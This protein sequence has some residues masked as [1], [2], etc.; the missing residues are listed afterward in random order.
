VL[1]DSDAPGPQMHCMQGPALRYMTEGL[2]VHVPRQ[3]SA[4]EAATSCNHVADCMQAAKGISF[5]EGLQAVQ[6]RAQQHIALLTEAINSAILDEQAVRQKRHTFTLEAVADM[7]K[8]AVPIF[9][10]G[11]AVSRYF[12][13]R[14]CAMVLLRCI[15]WHL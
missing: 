2:S 14:R 5:E 6:T 11:S 1:T 12:R 9:S 15:T 8:H 7:S 10:I 13:C 3:S 4:A